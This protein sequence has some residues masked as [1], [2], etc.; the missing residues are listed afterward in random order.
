MTTPTP[1]DE[2][3][4]HAAVV[5]A[6]S[7][8]AS[9]HVELGLELIGVYLIGSLAHGGFSR[10]YSDV[11]MAVVAEN[12]LNP[13]MIDRVRSEAAALSPEWGPKLSVFWTDRGFTIGR[14]P[15]LDRID[16][17][18]RPVVLLER[19]RVRPTPP[20]LAEIR[21]YLRGAPF[22]NWAERARAFASAATLDPKDRKP[23]L[24]ALLYPARFCYAFMTG[25]MGSN[26]DAVAFLQERPP[27]GL[28]L[29]SIEQALACRQAAADPD[30]LFALRSILPAQVDACEA[31]I[32]ASD[33]L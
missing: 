31:V 11:D 20:T 16:Y 27:A 10:R 17:L 4:S 12:G 1:P 3:A 28:D 19:E 18:E 33:F 7:L 30:P 2:A 6:C 13:D 25:R 26:D 23:Y 32:I 29:A 22:A 15:P 8:I 14:F 24:R 9:W 5:F 21:A